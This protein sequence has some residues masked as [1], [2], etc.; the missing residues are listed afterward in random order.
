MVK[1]EYE[2]VKYAVASGGSA[3]L[4]KLRIKQAV[5]ELVPHAPTIEKVMFGCQAEKGPRQVNIQSEVLQNI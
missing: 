1:D 4:I 2:I 3:V 5:W